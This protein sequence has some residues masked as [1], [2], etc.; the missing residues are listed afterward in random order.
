MKKS[1]NSLTPCPKFD[2]IEHN[3]KELA[4]EVKITP[5]D[6]VTQLQKDIANNNQVICDLKDEVGKQTQLL[7]NILQ[8]LW[9][10]HPAF[11][12]D[13]CLVLDMVAEFGTIAISAIHDLEIKEQAR[14]QAEATTTHF[15]AD[16]EASAV[17]A[18]A[19]DGA[20][21]SATPGR[22]ASQVDDDKEWE[23]NFEEPSQSEGSTRMK[24]KKSTLTS[25]SQSFL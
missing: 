25:L 24:M 14:S 6:I 18:T 4:I 1:L 10:P 21:T 9:T 7:A 13:N 12:E 19:K 2:S 20:P 3:I 17:V 5:Y 16:V 23:M 11:T 22:V 8:L 15:K